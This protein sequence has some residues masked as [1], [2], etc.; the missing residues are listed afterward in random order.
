[1]AIVGRDFYLT[2]PLRVHVCILTVVR[3]LLSVDLAVLEL[4][5]PLRD[6]I[7]KLETMRD[8]VSLRNPKVPLSRSGWSRHGNVGWV[9]CSEY[10]KSEEF[11]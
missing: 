3:L 7:R 1:M 5:S 2:I 8:M 9:K 11:N 10:V 4:L 6:S